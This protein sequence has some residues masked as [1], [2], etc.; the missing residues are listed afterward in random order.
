[1]PRWMFGWIHLAI[2][3]AYTGNSEA[4]RASVDRMLTLSPSFSIRHYYLVSSSK[5]DWMLNKAAHGLR[6]AGLPE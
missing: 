6:L 4:A 3:E 1:M 2:S 5:Y